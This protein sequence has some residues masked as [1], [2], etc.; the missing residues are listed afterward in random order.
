MRPRKMSTTIGP[1]PTL[2]IEPLLYLALE[3]GG[4]PGVGLPASTVESLEVVGEGK[5]DAVMAGCF[6]GAAAVLRVGFEGLDGGEL[7]GEGAAEFGRGDVVVA[8][9]ARAGIW[10][11]A[12]GL[13]GA[14]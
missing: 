8:G 3:G 4:H 9:F 1:E 13:G 14:Q 12:N 6:V 11:G 10:A 7:V 5:G 2:S